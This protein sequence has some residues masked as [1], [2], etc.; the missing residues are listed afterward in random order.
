MGEKMKIKIGNQLVE[1]LIGKKE[2]R[3]NPNIITEE[4]VL[5]DFIK[6]FDY[7]LKVVHNSSDY[8]TIQYHDVDI[9]RFKYGYSEYKGK[10]VKVF[11]VPKY[12]KKYIDNPLFKEQENKNQLFWK[13]TIENIEELNNF[14]DI[15]KE[16][17]EF[18]DEVDK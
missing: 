8:T 1:L 17:L 5:Y 4:S 14:I 16:D 12:K 2:E 10:W 7:D 18:R 13:S 9:L 3:Q 11:I 6:K 15:V